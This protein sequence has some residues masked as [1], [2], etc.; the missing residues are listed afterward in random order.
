MKK[1]IYVCYS[2]KG[3][4]VALAEY[5]RKFL[6]SFEVKN[7][8]VNSAG[9]GLENIESLRKRGLDSPSSNTS[10]ILL[11]EGFDIKDQKLK[12]IGDIISGT[13]LILTSDEFTLARLRSEFPYYRN[14]SFLAR[15]Y[16]G[17]LRNLDI[18]GPYAE[19]RKTRMGGRW[20]EIAGYRDM[21]KEIKVVSRRI[22]SRIAE[23]GI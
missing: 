14:Q 8:L 21:L 22:A 7:V 17:F 4:S 18:F 19:V 6:E 1:L 9:I 11:E 10:K 23:K 2:N 5:T 12:F 15:Q 3:R 16:A 20:S 13:D